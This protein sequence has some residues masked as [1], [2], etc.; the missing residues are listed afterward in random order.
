MES[1]FKSILD[2]FRRLGWGGTVALSVGLAVGSIVLAAI[3]V[4][5]WPVDQFKGP[6]AP[7]FLERRHPV[8]RVMGLAAKNLLGY[9]VVLLGFVMALPGVP[10]QGLLLILIGVSLLNFPG[11][12]R[13]ERRLIRR[14]SVFR[15][16]NALRKR[17][18]QPA[19]EID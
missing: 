16:V 10:G 8:V 18:G 13:L 15:V 7:P 14:H 3:I 6:T 12:R 2:F 11:K 5:G 17:F 1:W 19:L 4:V 9:L